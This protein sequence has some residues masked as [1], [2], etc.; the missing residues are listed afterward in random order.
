MVGLYQVEITEF[1]GEV[2]YFYEWLRRRDN[3]VF[4]AFTD[5]IKLRQTICKHTKW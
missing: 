2:R 4:I 1:Y 3:N 5:K